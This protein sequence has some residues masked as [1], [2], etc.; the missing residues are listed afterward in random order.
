MIIKILLKK[1]ELNL[2]RNKLIKCFIKRGCKNYPKWNHLLVIRP[3]NKSIVEITTSSM[4]KYKHVHTLNL[5]NFNSFMI[6]NINLENP[7]GQWKLSTIK[8][9]LNSN[10]FL[11]NFYVMII[12][13]FKWNA[14]FIENKMKITLILNHQINLMKKMILLTPNKLNKLLLA[15]IF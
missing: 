2:K 12:K 15:T 9:L 11:H 4:L 13:S 7:K 3:F 1:K 5:R 8:T 6:L 10:L 14:N